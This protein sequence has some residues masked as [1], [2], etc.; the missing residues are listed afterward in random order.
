M[1]L[2]YLHIQELVY[3]HVNCVI[4]TPLEMVIQLE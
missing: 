3:L 2:V 4:L 1:S